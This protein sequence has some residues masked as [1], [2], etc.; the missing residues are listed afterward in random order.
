MIKSIFKIK[1][2]ERK[3]F[4][5]VRKDVTKIP[6]LKSGKDLICTKRRILTYYSSSGMSWITMMMCIFK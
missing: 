3:R 6:F 2:D 5:V 1:R 4:H